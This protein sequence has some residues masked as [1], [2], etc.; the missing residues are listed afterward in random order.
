MISIGTSRGT[1]NE[2][3]NR[4]GLEQLIARL[5]LDG[6]WER[7]TAAETLTDLGSKALDCLL[8]DIASR[9]MG[10][11]ARQSYLYILERQTEP[12]A[13]IRVRHVLTALR[14][15]SYRLAA[16]LAAFR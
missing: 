10:D 16:P 2:G 12:S 15:P 8:H 1:L 9:P 7:W 6:D 11:R 5:T 4:A 13:I 14:W 3:T